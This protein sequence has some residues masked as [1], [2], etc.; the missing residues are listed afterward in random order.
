MRVGLREANQNF[1]RIMKAVRKG[2]EVILTDRGRPVAK[3]TRLE[4]PVNQADDDFDKILD[5]LEAEGFLE[6]APK[7]GQRMPPFKP[8]KIR[9]ELITETLR[10]ERDED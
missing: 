2:T 8:I 7:R 3:I 9:G 10:R 1:S 5:Q 4:P 6:R